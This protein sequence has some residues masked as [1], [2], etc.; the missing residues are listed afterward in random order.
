MGLFD[1]WRR[2]KRGTHERSQVR[3]REILVSDSVP[4]KAP[5]VAELPPE[6][7]EEVVKL[8]AEYE[9]L[10]RRRDELQTERSQLTVRLD[11]GELTAIEFRKEL[12]SRIQ[13]AAQ[14][15]ER[16]KQVSSRLIELGYRGI[17]R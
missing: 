2:R 16:L 10:V 12:M 5:V 17:L 3:A 6:S 1:S 14:V 7:Q 9:R 13:E 15:A 4:T 8:V 11:S